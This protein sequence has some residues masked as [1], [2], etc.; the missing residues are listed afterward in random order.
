MSTP[1]APGKAPP[2]V[3]DL[4]FVDDT[5]LVGPGHTEITR[6]TDV[7]TEFFGMHG[8][9]IN[10]KKT[11]LLAINPTHIDNI[12]YGGSLIQPQAASK[13]S[14]VLGVWLAVNGSAKTTAADPSMDSHRTHHQEI[15]DGRATKTRFTQL[16]TIQYTAPHKA[17]RTTGPQGRSRRTTHQHIASEKH[18]E[19][20]HRRPN[21]L[22]TSRPA[23]GGKTAGIPTFQSGHRQ[24][25]I[26]EFPQI[27]MNRVEERE[28]ENQGHACETQ[29]TEEE[30]VVLW[31]FGS[32]DEEEPPQT[33]EKPRIPWTPPKATGDKAVDRANLRAFKQRRNQIIDRHTKIRREKEVRDKLRQQAAK[34]AAEEGKCRKK[35]EKQA[36]LDRRRQE[37]ESMLPPKRRLMRA[38]K[39]RLKEL[40]T[41]AYPLLPAIKERIQHHATSNTPKHSYNHINMDEATQSAMEEQRKH[42]QPGV[43]YIY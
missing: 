26:S 18:P 1:P 20:A 34:E 23:K 28:E 21:P 15:Q 24:H 4:A 7:G 38:V 37:L 41:E 31:E 30:E 3:S 6:M 36:E 8:I 19:R 40:E 25:A 33:P 35:T 22:P 9:E 12:N 13:V 5:S 17:V 32:E 14:R 43:R 29:E 27:E 11:E 16:N 42:T 10:G 39:A 2:I